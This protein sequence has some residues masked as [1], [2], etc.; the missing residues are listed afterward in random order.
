MNNFLNK[1]KY[2]IFFTLLIIIYLILD[3]QS[4]LFYRP[5]GIHF[6]RQTDCLSFVSNYF[7][8]KNNFFEPQV[9]NLTSTE[10]RAACEFPLLYYVTSQLY[11]L[12]GEQEF[13]LRL[14]TIIIVTFGFFYL[15]K[16]LILILKDIH[17]AMIFSYLFLSSTVLLYYTN[18][19]L[20]DAS[21]LGFTLIGWF[22]FF[23]Y[24]QN[25]KHLILSFS[26]FTLSSLIKATY[27]INPITALL[28]IIIIDLIRKKKLVDIIKTNFLLLLIFTISLLFLLSWILYTIHYNAINKDFYFLVSTRPIWDLKQEGINEV[29]NY[30]SN[31]WYSKY[32]YQSTIH[33]FFII[34][35][36]GVIFIKKANKTILIPNIILFIGSIIY[37]LLFYAQ[38]KE[39]DYYFI[40]L[41]P[42]II[43]FVITAFTSIIN[44]F[45][46]LLNHFIAKI[47]LMVL[48]VLSINHARV[49]LDDRYDNKLDKFDEIGM[50]LSNARVSID[51]LG[52]SQKAKIIVFTDQTPNGGL[53]FLN[54]KGWNIT[55]TTESNIKKI[56][57]YK[58]LGANYLI[59]TTN[60]NFNYL[61]IW[62]NG[63][64]IIYKI[65]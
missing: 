39:H 13:I 26:F 27:F 56:D 5:Q 61:K 10:G 55:D 49:K 29:W 14:I 35:I 36:L 11:R 7:N 32:Y 21:A 23:L 62:E 51:S 41:I 20:P 59:N 33:F 47:L 42:A 60:L 31:Y 40:T 6:I 46:R 18:N 63:K 57:E 64:V 12:F 34:C 28:T 2:F 24:Q 43:F 17:Y 37:L 9:F 1:Y 44:K 22:H 3:Y 65:E 50:V 19:F 58:N 15:F 25:K 48:T 16:L 4:I 54:R 38:F 45:P 8:N 30:I 52:I 53:Y